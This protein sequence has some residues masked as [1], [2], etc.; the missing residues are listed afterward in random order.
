MSVSIKEQK[1]DSTSEMLGVM[2]SKVWMV[3]SSGEGR[4]TR[5]GLQEAFIVFKNT[6]GK[7][8]FDST[9]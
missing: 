9:W 1:T 3:F 4:R 5:E 7:I 8:R 6:Y 2:R